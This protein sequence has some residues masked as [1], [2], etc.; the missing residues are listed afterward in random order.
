MKNLIIFFRISY[1]IK[2]NHLHDSFI[3]I[4]SIVKISFIFATFFTTCLAQKGGSYGKT[5]LNENRSPARQIQ[6]QQQQQI[7]Q[8]AAIAPNV[9]PIVQQTFQPAPV[10]QVSLIID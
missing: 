9:Q 4:Q 3:C 6:Q 2:N 1:P 7:L 5:L 10:Q 8:Q